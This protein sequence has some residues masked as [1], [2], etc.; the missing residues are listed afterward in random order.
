MASNI[1]VS[2]L[3]VA[4]GVQQ[5]YAQWAVDDPNINGLPYLQLDRVELWASTTNDRSTASKVAEGITFANYVYTGFAK[6]YHWIRARDREGQYGDWYPSSATAGQVAGGV[7]QDFDADVRSGT[8]SITTIDVDF[9]KY[10]KIGPIVTMSVGVSISSNGTGAGA[11]NFDPPITPV[12]D[13]PIVGSGRGPGGNFVLGGYVTTGLGFV[14]LYDGSYPGA[15][16]TA[17]RWSAV[18]EADE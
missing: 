9:S 5:T 13:W 1:T 14:Y 17:L 11:I 2:D 4:P 18:Y 3:V 15:N 16:S 10:Y 12:S 8:G 7:F 6:R